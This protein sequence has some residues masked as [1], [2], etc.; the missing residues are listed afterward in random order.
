MS[1][2]TLYRL[3]LFYIPTK[4]HSLGQQAFSGIRNITTPHVSTKMDSRLA[5][6]GPTV[7]HRDT[8]PSSVH[9]PSESS[10]L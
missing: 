6:L 7:E 5:G 10:I 3:T 4:G 2:G 1:C 9:K 8:M